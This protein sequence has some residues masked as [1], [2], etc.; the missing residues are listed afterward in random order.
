ME[1]LACCLSGS[2]I[3][4]KGDA[5]LFEGLLSRDLVNLVRRR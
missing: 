3:L 2:L 1:R 4:E 5:V